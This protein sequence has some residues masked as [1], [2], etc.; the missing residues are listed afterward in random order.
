MRKTTGNITKFEKGKSGNPGGRP[1]TIKVD[2]K[3]H[4]VKFASHKVPVFKEK[5]GK[6]Y[7]LFGENNAYPDYLLKARVHPRD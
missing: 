5:S 3:V 2:G 6:K 4:V 1:A 7:I